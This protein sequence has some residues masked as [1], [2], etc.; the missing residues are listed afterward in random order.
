MKQFTRIEPT[1]IQTVGGKFK[2]TIVVKRYRTEDGLTHEFTTKGRENSHYGGVIALTTD[3]KVLCVY[4]FRAGPERWLYEIPGGKLHDG[5]DFQVG[6]LR[7]LQEET[8]YVPSKIEFLGESMRDSYSNSTWHFYLATEC[9]PAPGGIKPDQTEIDQG[10]ELKLITIDELI[11]HAKHDQLSD[12]HAV[13][14][15]YERLMELKQEGIQ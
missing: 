15:A 1:T 13:F 4:Q 5:E 11:E 3:K 9:A 8:G 2:D 6:V 14:L 10:A 7:E 12:P